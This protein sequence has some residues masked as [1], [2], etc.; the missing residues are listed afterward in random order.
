MIDRVPP[1]PETP[2][3]A[4]PLYGLRTWAVVGEPG[5]ERLAGPHRSTPWPGGGGWLRATCTREPAHTAPAHDCVCGI[6]AFHP[7]AR[8]ARRV[9]A[10]RRDVAGVVECSGAVELHVEGFRAERGRPH[11]LAL[12]PLRNAGLIGRLAAAYDAEVADV[13]GASD[14]LDWCRERRLG[15]GAPVVAQLLGPV[16]VAEWRRTRR[17][18]TRTAA[19]RVAVAALVAAILGALAHAALPDASGPHDV[20]GRTGKVHVK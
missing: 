2:L 3:V 20:F 6:H 16:A 9:L 13:R 15:L 4:G 14:L 12:T 5:A 8:S 17:R 19:V 11:A 10:S 1:G 7:D 18:G